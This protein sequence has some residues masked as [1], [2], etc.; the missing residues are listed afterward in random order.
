[1]KLEY[2]AKTD[3]G[4]VRDHNEDS[5]GV[6]YEGDLFFVCDGMGGHAAGDYASQK[7]VETIIG[8]MRKY[9]SVD[10]DQIILKEPAQIPY[11]GRLLTSM[12]MLAN[13]RLFRLAV[14]YPKLRGM[15]TTIS[16]L[17]FSEGYVNVVNVGDS[18]AYRFRD[19]ELSQ[20]SVDHSWVEEMLEDGEIG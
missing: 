13:R 19:S 15:G 4:R 12:V 14:M 10:L 3:V 18:R 20:L 5:F 8:L 2:T 16:S 6:Y 9:P 7:V 17:L 1:M 11:L